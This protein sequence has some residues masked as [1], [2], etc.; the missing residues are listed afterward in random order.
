MR[1]EK[2]KNKKK[3]QLHVEKRLSSQLL[4]TFLP[5]K[6]PLFECLM[7]KKTS[8]RRSALLTKTLV[9]FPPENSFCPRE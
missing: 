8:L 6:Q 3:T 2:K 9:N 5:E 1:G 7:K 4:I